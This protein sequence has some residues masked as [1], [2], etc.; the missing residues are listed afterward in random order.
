MGLFFVSDVA[1]GKAA[2]FSVPGVPSWIPVEMAVGF[3]QFTLAGLFLGMA[4]GVKKP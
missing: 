2:H 3:V 4:H 1:L